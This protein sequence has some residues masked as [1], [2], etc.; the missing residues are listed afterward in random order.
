MPLP[1]GETLLAKTAARALALSGVTELFT[2]TNRDYYFHTRDA[3]AGLRDV[4]AERAVFLLEPFGRNTAPARAS[5]AFNPMAR[6][7]V[8]LPAFG[9]PT[10]PTS[11]IRRSSRAILRSTPGSPR[12]A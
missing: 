2:V 6:S 12:S 4:P 8:L 9:T 7:N 3:Y 1:D 5:T 10:I 11:A